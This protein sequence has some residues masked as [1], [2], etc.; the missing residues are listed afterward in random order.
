MFRKIVAEAVDVENA[1]RST[2]G[3]KITADL[4][5]IGD[6]PSG[7]TSPET[8]ELRQLTATMAVFDKVP[9]WETSSTDANIPIGLGIPAFAIGRSSGGRAGRSHSLDEWTDVEKTQAVKDFEVTA[10]Q[11]LSVAGVP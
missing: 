1:T 4:K 11:I 2:A 6:R 8:P 10:A 7:T 9:V 3:G 5:L